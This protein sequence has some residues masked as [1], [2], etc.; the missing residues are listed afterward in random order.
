VATM[1]RKEFAEV[2]RRHR[3]LKASIDLSRSFETIAAQHKLRDWEKVEVLFEHSMLYTR[4]AIKERE[5]C[6]T[7][8]L[9]RLRRKS[10]TSAA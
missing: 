9:K 6:R 4:I 10:S 2:K 3:V 1:S 8:K 5:A 7:T